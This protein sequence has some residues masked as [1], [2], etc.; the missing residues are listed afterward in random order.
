MGNYTCVRREARIQAVVRIM[1]SRPDT[2]P[3][4]RDWRF[5]RRPAHRRFWVVESERV[6]TRLCFVWRVVF[7]EACA[8]WPG[9]HAEWM[10]GGFVWLSVTDLLT[11]AGSGPREFALL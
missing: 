1:H 5:A 2:G 6:I 11:T 10:G 8:V 3:D 4:P 9:A 7:A